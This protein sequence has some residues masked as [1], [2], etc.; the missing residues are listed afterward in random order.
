M[1]TAAVDVSESLQQ[2]ID[3]LIAFLPKLLGSY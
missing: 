2:G 3:D 1:Y